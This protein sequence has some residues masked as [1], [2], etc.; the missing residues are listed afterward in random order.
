MSRYSRR[1]LVAAKCAIIALIAFIAGP[2][3]ADTPG[4][5]AVSIVVVLLIAGAAAAAYEA[6]SH[7]LALTLGRLSGPDRALTR[8]GAVAEIAESSPAVPDNRLRSRHVLTALVAY[9][10]A[11]AVVWIC[12]A[13]VAVTQVGTAGDPEAFTRALSSYITIAL[14][15]SIV[16]GCVAL[17]LVLRNW[18]RRLGPEGLSVL[19]GLSW[20]TAR[21]I[22]GG[23]AAGAALSAIVLPLLAYAWERPATPDPV[24]H[25]LTSSAAARWAWI[26]SA[27]LLAPPVEEIM[28]RGVLL[29]G[30]AET[31]NVRAAA[32]ISGG[33]FWLMHAPEWT[34]WPAAVAIGLLTI[35]VTRLRL[36][37]GALGPSMAAHFAYNL[38]LTA[39][40][41][42][43]RPEGVTPPGSE[44]SKWAQ[45]PRE[46]VPVPATFSL[47]R[48]T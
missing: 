16:A 1:Q 32:L 33:T 41:A 40:L 38:L 28:F 29:G 36:R 24:T 4:E 42:G 34:H 27:V 12:T 13:I 10:G 47:S 22:A 7:A 2:Q 37:S 45:L 31:W 43:V 17:L 23:L 18:S 48:S 39:A 21:Q 19:L 35:V 20:G 6:L 30:L 9:M 5:R 11:Q 3:L 8:L 25:I 26:L 44:G 46:Q 14:P 15:A